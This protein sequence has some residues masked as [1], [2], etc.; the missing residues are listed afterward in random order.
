M[1]Y[2]LIWIIISIWK[3]QHSHAAFF[4]C[5]P[6]MPV[7]CFW[8]L[9][10]LGGQPHL[11]LCLPLIEAWHHI[12]NIGIPSNKCRF[13]NK[14]ECRA[15][16]ET[17]LISDFSIL[18]FKQFYKY[19]FKFICT[20]LPLFFVKSCCSIKIVSKHTLIIEIFHT[21]YSFAYKIIKLHHIFLRSNSSLCHI[22]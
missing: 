18:L 21:I 7:L 11:I 20:F 17:H 2:F 13:K 22:C 1:V 15:F 5:N 19:I 14:Q 10:K 4:I 3:K 16:Q 9:A 12:R 8:V 6:K